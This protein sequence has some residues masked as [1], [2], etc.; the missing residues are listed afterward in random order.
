MNERQITNA[1][2]RLIQAGRN[3]D[4]L[5]Y[6]RLLKETQY[7]PNEINAELVHICN[8][9]LDEYMPGADEWLADMIDETGRPDRREFTCPGCGGPFDSGSAPAAFAHRPGCL[10]R[11][12]NG[13]KRFDLKA[14]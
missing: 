7:L 2:L 11:H 8:G 6:F 13:G 3:G 4:G 12:R 1:A 10:W 9:L 5:A 14:N